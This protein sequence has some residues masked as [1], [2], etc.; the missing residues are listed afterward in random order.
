MTM[1][2]P[3][4]KQLETDIVQL[5]DNLATLADDSDMSELLNMIH[6]P[7]WTTPTESALVAGLVESLRGHTQLIVDLRQIL[8]TG[9]RQISSDP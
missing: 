1:I 7:G 4:V 5:R 9:C 2:K 8:I 3:D 6:R